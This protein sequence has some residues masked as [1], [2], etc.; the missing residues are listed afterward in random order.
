M[1]GECLFTAV[2]AA[3]VRMGI[4]ALAARYVKKL[5]VFLVPDTNVNWTDVCAGV[6]YAE[7]RYPGGMVKV[8]VSLACSLVLSSPS[9]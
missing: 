6:L 5:L 2:G 7:H 9:K 4:A 3:T 8:E 1:C